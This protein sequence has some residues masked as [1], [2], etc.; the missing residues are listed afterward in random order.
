MTV[1]I[2]PITAEQTHTLRHDILRPGQP[3]ENLIY[4][5]DDAPNTLHVGA[6]LDGNLV[7]IASVFHD[8]P[9]GKIDEGDWRL[10]GM[11]ILSDVRGRGYGAELLKRCIEHVTGQGG[12]RLWCN[13]R[14]EVVGFYTRL[15]FI[16][17]GEAYE[18]PGLGI[19]FFMWRLL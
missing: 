3:P 5:K 14:A 2:K 9:P 17:E 12:R 7:G 6:F 4:P 18:L 13:A 15:G 8:A 11:A 19:H 16:V 1:E 10:R